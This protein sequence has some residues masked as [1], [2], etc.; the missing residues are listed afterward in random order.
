MVVRSL[1]GG[2][3]DIQSQQT[4]LEI[5]S[6]VET[7]HGKRNE[8][9]SETQK[10]R[11]QLSDEKSDIED[12]QAV[13]PNLDMEF[14]GNEIE[15]ELENLVQNSF[16]DRIN[17]LNEVLKNHESRLDQMD[18][19]QNELKRIN[20]II[21]ARVAFEQ[22]FSFNSARVIMVCNPESR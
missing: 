21:S 22:V 12:I 14:S 15:P 3:S 11:F 5:L 17:D 10:I 13:N 4:E 1:K 2:Q 19:I 20:T 9:F 8:V 18:F 6:Q 7:Q 16:D